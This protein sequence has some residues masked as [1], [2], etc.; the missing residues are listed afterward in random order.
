MTAVGRRSRGGALDEELVDV[1]GTDTA[2]RRP[3]RARSRR[4]H[5]HAMRLAAVRDEAALVERG[6]VEQP[7][8]GGG[9]PVEVTPQP[10][11]ALGEEVHDEP[12]GTAPATTV[13]MGSVT[14]TPRSGWITTRS[15]R[16]RGER[17]SVYR[18]S[19]PGRRATAAD[20]VATAAVAVTIPPAAGVRRG[21]RS[22]R[23][24]APRAGRR[25]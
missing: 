25:R 3:A 23:H 2:D 9:L 24:R 7:G 12:V 4:H 14:T 10:R 16:A 6:P 19:P 21:P 8:A 5:M 15:R 20:S 17:R 18:R 1:V 11:L 13:A 22:P